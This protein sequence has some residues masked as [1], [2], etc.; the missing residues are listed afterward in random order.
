MIRIREFIT[1]GGSTLDDIGLT[2]AITERMPTTTVADQ[3]AWMNQLELSL[4]GYGGEAQ[5]RA[6]Q[7]VRAAL[8]AI[9][10]GLDTPAVSV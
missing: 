6:A 1:S 3:R 2:A 10:A 9:G 4:D 5:L 7:R 8:K